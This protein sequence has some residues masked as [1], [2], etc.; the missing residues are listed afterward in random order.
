MRFFWTFEL[1]PPAPFVPP[2]IGKLYRMLTA[3][4][5]APIVKTKLVGV[6]GVPLT[7]K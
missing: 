7:E 5:Y 4:E 2:L 6:S 3:R 1:A